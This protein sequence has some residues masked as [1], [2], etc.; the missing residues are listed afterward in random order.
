[1]SSKGDTKKQAILRNRMIKKSKTRRSRYVSKILTVLNPKSSLLDI[2][3]GTAHIIQE[4]A[5]HRKESKLVGLD[6]SR[7]MLKVAKKNCAGLNNIELLIG[8]GLIQPFPDQVF[9]T[10]IT[11]LAEYSPKEAYRVLKKGGIFLEYGLGPEADKEIKEFFPRRIEKENFFFPRNLEEWKQEVCEDI[12]EAGFS[13]SE[14][15]DYKE[16]DYYESEEDLM[17]LIEVVPLVKN[18]D[19]D[20]DGRTIR[21]LA[22]KYRSNKGVKITWHYYILMAR[23]Y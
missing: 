22:A 19:R 18:F 1:M 3:C 9:D 2:G 13:V 15:S 16:D 12:V 5:T 21:E 20:K 14:I 11:R 17:D 10:Q 23:K 6:V 4:L 8:D 7:A